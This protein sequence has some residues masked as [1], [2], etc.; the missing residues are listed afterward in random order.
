MK[1]YFGEFFLVV[2]LIL[3]S[4]FFAT[5]LADFPAY[6]F[7]CF[8]SLLLIWGIY[9]IWRSYVPPPPSCK[10]SPAARQTRRRKNKI[11]LRILDEQA[12]SAF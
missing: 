7:F 3:L 5:N 4:V 11:K 10:V 12:D 6:G 8:G 9:L 1:K 2:G